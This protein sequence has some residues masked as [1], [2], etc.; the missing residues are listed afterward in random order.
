[1]GEKTK[2]LAWLLL[3]DGHSV[4]ITSLD[5]DELKD[6][7]DEVAVRD[8]YALG[9]QTRLNAIVKCFGFRGDFGNYST[10]H[11]PVLQTLLEEHGLHTRVDLLKVPANDAF[12]IAPGRRNLADR[13]FFGPGPRPRRVFTGFGYDWGRWESLR[14]D[15]SIARVD[16]DEHE[17]RPFRPSSDEDAL[18]WLY[19]RRGYLPRTSVRGDQL[20]SPSSGRPFDFGTYWLATVPDEERERDQRRDEEL[21][22]VFRWLIERDSRGW[23]EIIE[24][25]GEGLLVLKGPDGQYDLLWRNLR[26]G[27]PPKSSRGAQ[28]LELAPVDRP[29]RLQTRE[30]FAAWCYYRQDVWEDDERHRAEVHHYASGGQA[31]IAYPGADAV[32]ER[33]LRDTQVY[34]EMPPYPKAKAGPS[35]F[36]RVE[37]PGRAVLVSEL[38]TIEDMKSM[39]AESGY[40]DRRVGDRWEPGNMQ[41]HPDLPATAT[42]W[43]TQA[44]CAWME[45]NLGVGVRLPFAEEYRHWCPKT[46]R[47]ESDESG[48]VRCVEWLEEWK[49]VFG[50]PAACRFTGELPWRESPVGLVLLDGD[51]FF[52]WTQDEATLNGWYDG[53]FGRES[54][55]AYK[56]SKVGFRLVIELEEG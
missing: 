13:L 3:R 44:Y 33:Y 41:D 29:S 27:P 19:A 34:G 43:D 8:G 32:Y 21:H 35:G 54:W 7:A 40:P 4:P 53:G 48:R 1:M 25:A 38:V 10:D 11:W 22:S 24:T 52:E 56:R 12:F 42:W 16:P 51:D 9:W 47:V 5:P 18:R 45:R 46:P 39:W 6:A 26:E 28:S 17:A 2:I 14:D 20:F 36:K 31:G 55:G 49:G 37:V 30:A 50:E 15:R 23:V